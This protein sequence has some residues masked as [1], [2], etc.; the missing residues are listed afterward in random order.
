MT[1]LS[2]GFLHCTL[3]CWRLSYDQCQHICHVGSKFQAHLSRIKRGNYFGE[4]DIKYSVSLA[5]LPNRHQGDFS[6]P[7]ESECGR[8]SYSKCAT[9]S[10]ASAV[11]LANRGLMLHWT[12]LQSFFHIRDAGREMRVTM[13]L[14]V[15][16]GCWHEP[17]L[18]PHCKMSRL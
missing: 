11:P 8:I 18:S 13:N 9:S 16:P 10:E 7:L 2:G 14:I 17:T 3:P 12:R 15:A 1:F 5:S 6:S 4:Q